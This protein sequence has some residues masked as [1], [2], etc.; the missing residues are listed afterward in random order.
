MHDPLHST[1][2]KIAAS[3]PTGDPTR[4]KILAAL[5]TARPT[6]EQLNQHSNQAVRSFITMMTR[7]RGATKELARLWDLLLEKPGDLDHAKA[8]ANQIGLDWRMATFHTRKL[9]PG[10]RYPSGRDMQ[11]AAQDEQARRDEAAKQPRTKEV[12]DSRYKE[13][14]TVTTAGLRPYPQLDA[15]GAIEGVT[16]NLQSEGSRRGF[17]IK[18]VGRIAPGRT[19]TSEYGD[20]MARVLLSRGGQQW[21][22]RLD[23]YGQASPLGDI[24]VFMTLSVQ[25]AARR[26]VLEMKDRPANKSMWAGLSQAILDAIG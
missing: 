18:L 16:Q 21:T 1:I 10:E 6:Y 11:K 2:L 19:D 12:W 3:L 26:S 14:R 13:Y 20:A 7:S 9:K 22:A 23:A 25:D 8:A 5:K 15:I 24:N 17:Q 4:R